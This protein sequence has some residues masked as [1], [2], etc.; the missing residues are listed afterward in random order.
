MQF[1]IKQG[2]DLLVEADDVLPASGLGHVS[3]G[4]AVGDDSAPSTPS[5]E[6]GI[7]ACDGSLP[8]SGGASGGAGASRKPPSSVPRRAVGTTIEVG[9]RYKGINHD[10]FVF[11][12]LVTKNP[13]SNVTGISQCH[14]QDHLHCKRYSLLSSTGF[15]LD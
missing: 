9:Q 12:G 4:A 14:D 8:G 13:I 6:A 2:Y 15:I 1:A 3:A 11:S 5:D 7:G 10:S